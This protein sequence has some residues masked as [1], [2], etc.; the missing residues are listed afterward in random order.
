[1]RTLICLFLL[2]TAVFAN[3]C[4]SSASGNWNDSSIWTSCGGTVPGNG[5][6]LTIAAGHTITVPAGY[7]AIVGVSGPGGAQQSGGGPVPA[8]QCATEQT[9]TSVLVVN[10]TLT[11]RGNVEQCTAVWRVGQDAILEHDSSL[12]PSP[13]TTHY[14]WII[15]TYLWPDAAQLVIRGTVGH[16]VTIRNAASSGTFYGLTYNRYSDQGSGQFD[17]EYVNIDGCGGASPCVD[18]TSHNA[19]TAS[20]GRCDHC[21][22]TNSGYFGASTMGGAANVVRITSSTFTS[23]AD[24]SKYVFRLTPGGASSIVVDTVFTTGAIALFGDAGG[25]ATG[26]HIRNV[27]VNTLSND[28]PINLAG[29]HFKVAEFDLVL[30][31][32]DR[33]GGGGNTGTPA[34]LPGGALTRIMCLM[35]SNLNPHCFGIA[36]DGT[37]NDSVNG[38]YAE[39]IGTGSDGDLFLGGP[40]GATTATFSNF[41]SVCSTA[42]GLSMGTFNNVTTSTSGHSVMTQNTICGKDGGDGTGMGASLEVWAGAAGLF[43]AIKNNITYSAT[44]SPTYLVRQG[45]SLGGPPDPV[46]GVY[47]GVDYNWKWNVATGPYYGIAADYASPAPPGAH[48]SS[49]DPQ[50]VQQRHFLDWGQMLKPSI[51]TW[52]DIVAEFAKMNDDVGYDSRFNILNAYN[53]LRDGYRPGNAAVMNAGD[54]GG[55]VGAMDAYGTPSLVVGRGK[56]AGPSVI[57]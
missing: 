33:I 34:Y 57:K 16:R 1:M 52:T 2:S 19:A 17:F 36:G 35:N 28:Y 21:L 26:T 13:S 4:V 45:P 43:N 50:F 32:T 11:F 30:R 10:G 14:R 25:S 44:N 39:K 53:W 37:T 51:S 42:D 23:P 49:G 46:A 7:R 9:T 38:G 31:I 15:G 6:T 24:P 5:D 29:S 3:A 40:V 48:D 20:I 27:V 18:S 41:V 54:T 22:V 8:I 55:R 47:N 12:A 56:I